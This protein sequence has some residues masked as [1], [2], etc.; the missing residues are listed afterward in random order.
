MFQPV[1]HTEESSSCQTR[2]NQCTLYWLKAGSNTA[3]RRS[4]DP[5]L[6]K[7]HALDIVT[8]ARKLQRVLSTTQT[9]E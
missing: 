4:L 5:D 3:Q 7:C 1:W 9:A 8:R 6:D 2:S